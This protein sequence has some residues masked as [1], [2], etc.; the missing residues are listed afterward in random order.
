MFVSF[1]FA[2]D[3]YLSPSDGEDW[4]GEGGDGRDDKG[5]VKGGQHRQNLEEHH[6]STSFREKKTDSTFSMSLY[7]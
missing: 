1:D 2:S 7:H 6:I 4:Q 3:L 5:R